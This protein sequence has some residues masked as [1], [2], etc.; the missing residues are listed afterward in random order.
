MLILVLV[1][2]VRTFH[3][4]DFSTSLFFGLP[5]KERALVL[6]NIHPPMTILACPECCGDG[7]CLPCDRTCT[8]VC[9]KAGPS[10]SLSASEVV[11]LLERVGGGSVASEGDSDATELAV[12]RP[13]VPTI[14]TFRL[15]GKRLFITYPRCMVSPATAL[16]AFLAWKPC[17]RALVAQEQ[18]EDG[19]LHLHVLIWLKRR[20]DLRTPR[21]LDR[22]I[23]KH[24]NYQIM[25]DPVKS[26][27]Y[28][29]KDGNYVA[30]GFDPKEYLESSKKKRSGSVN[31]YE[32]AEWVQ[33]GKSLV[34]FPNQAF[35]ARNLRQL[36][37]YR[38]WLATQRPVHRVST[39]GTPYV[40]R[41][42]VLFGPT[43]VGKSRW[44]NTGLHKI[45][46]APGG[47]GSAT[48]YVLPVQRSGGVWWDGYM[49][50][51]VLVLDEFD[52]SKVALLNL[53]R[54]LDQYKYTG[55]VKGGTM[56]AD[57]T[58]VIITC[59]HNP[60]DW[61]KEASHARLQAL[62]RRIKICYVRDRSFAVEDFD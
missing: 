14:T 25:K 31:W 34:E 41:T 53:L 48:T 39:N 10:G 13:V 22:V 51:Q 56:T 42:V 33:A 11:D 4:D 57:W 2:F 19:G 49:G 54:I 1:L 21:S 36:Q 26:V 29:M 3:S 46:D 35:I 32:A 23:G 17:E 28:C 7:E 20:I 12:R 27:E 50:E 61:Y 37:L 38:A 52:P 30:H 45:R 16:Q 18:H 24:G 8:C 60:R 47:V 55:M 40:V 15:A 44:A 5:S 58:E 59:Q 43:G 62:L 6:L 9:H